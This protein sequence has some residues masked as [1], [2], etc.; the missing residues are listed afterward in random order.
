MK[1]KSET[2][3]TDARDIQLMVKLTLER[4]SMT[5]EQVLNAGISEASFIRNAPAVAASVRAANMEF[6]A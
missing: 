1:T 4:G 3:A 6:A 5:K 2:T